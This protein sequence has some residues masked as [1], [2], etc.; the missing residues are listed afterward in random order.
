MPPR[1]K[2]LI[3][4]AVLLPFLLVYVFAAAAIGE[5]IPPNELLRV[6]YYIVAGILWAAPVRSLIMWAN[7]E[8]APNRDR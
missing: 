6:P 3:A 4:L 5:Q 2:K 8:P 1:I 7:A